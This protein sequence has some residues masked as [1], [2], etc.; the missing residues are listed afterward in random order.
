[1]GQQI[2]RRI[3]LIDKTLQLKF[4]RLF[5]GIMFLL[6]GIIGA[7]SYQI[8]NKIIEKYLYST[9][10]S[11][12]SSGEIILP[13]LLW[14][15]LCF[16][17]LLTLVTVIYVFFHLRHISGSL[18]RF[19]THLDKMSGH[20]TPQAIH[21]HRN[22]PLY[23]VANDFNIMADYLGKKNSVTRDYLL[24]AV[25][26]LQGLRVSLTADNQISSENFKEIQHH[27]ITAEKEIKV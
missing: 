6:T 21:L 18:R 26:G 24:L 10:I 17:V 27:L 15:N 11:P 20:S 19:S 22:D 12:L 5:V 16:A 14:I 25:A 2:K 7:V 13:A 4:V 23:M 9:H 3:Y 1:M 8:L